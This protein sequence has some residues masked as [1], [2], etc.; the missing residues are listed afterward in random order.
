MQITEI[1][2]SIQGEGI[3]TGLPSVFIR[4]TGCNLRCTY[5]DTTYAYENG[6]EMSIDQIISK[7]EKYQCINICIT[8]GE[9]L[10]Q[11]DTLRLIRKLQE[12]KYQ[13][14]LETNGSIPLPLDLNKNN[15]MI[16][17]DLKMPSSKMHEHMRFENLKKLTENDQLKCII[18]HKEDYQYAK[19]MVKDFQP[20]CHI[21]F[22]P[23]WGSDMEKLA[24]WILNDKLSVRMGVQLHKLVWG[25]K[26]QR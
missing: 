14:S 19:K 22:Q 2:F 18:Q 23:V 8:G 17:M 15:L 13:I 1:F 21:I 6:K 12:K 9:P 7:I 25:E 4:T 5:C 26:T 3:H 10:L 11:N 16:S 20:I 24:E